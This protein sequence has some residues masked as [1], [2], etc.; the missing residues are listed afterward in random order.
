MKLQSLPALFIILLHAFS[1][2][3]SHRHC[4][5]YKSSITL[6]NEPLMILGHQP[7]VN[8]GP[9]IPCQIRGGAILLR[10]WHDHN[11]TAK[12]DVCP[13]FW[14]FEH[15]PEEKR[16]RVIQCCDEVAER[17]PVDQNC[18][19]AQEMFNCYYKN[20]D[21]R[22]VEKFFIPRAELQHARVLTDCI[23]MLQI[24]ESELDLIRQ[25]GILNH[26]RG[27]CLVRCFLLREDLYSEESGPRPFRILVEKGGADDGIEFRKQGERCI[28]RLQRN[29]LDRCTLA[30]RIADECYDQ[31]LLKIIDEG[32]K[33]IKT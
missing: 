31:T 1:V 17:L 19:R 27:R 8:I 15:N 24:S 14:Q 16:Q 25:E 33:N 2:R 20:L 6:F 26:P 11:A 3:S 4:L 7:S 13:R 30:A 5:Q 32:L 29:F 23:R 28:A 18:Q 22:W 9:M 21:F 10:I 12:N